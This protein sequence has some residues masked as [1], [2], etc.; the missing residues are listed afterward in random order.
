MAEEEGQEVTNTQLTIFD[1][2]L[3]PGIYRAKHD[4]K[5]KHGQVWPERKKMKVRH[6]EGCGNSI[7]WC[8]Q[9][10]DRQNIGFRLTL[11]E[12]KMNFERV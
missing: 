12:V 1:L 4:W 6:Q 9:M 8:Q 5:N 11:E 3:E 2:I 10:D 7:V